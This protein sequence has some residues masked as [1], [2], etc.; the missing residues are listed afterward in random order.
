MGPLESIQQ[1]FH[2]LM[3]TSVSM[4]AAATRPKSPSR[5][6]DLAWLLPTKHPRL[7]IILFQT[8][9]YHARTHTNSLTQASIQHPTRPETMRVTLSPLLVMLL[10]V[11]SSAFVPAA[12]PRGQ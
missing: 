3:E 6:V 11:S 2:T 5:R 10:S 9:P 4:A 12:A 1:P 8:P 7:L